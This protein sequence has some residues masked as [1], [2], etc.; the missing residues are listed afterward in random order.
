[1]TDNKDTTR[2]R[3]FACGNHNTEA[4]KKINIDPGAKQTLFCLECIMDLD[5]VAKDSLISLDAFV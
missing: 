3:G 4:V 5:R 1:M 2:L